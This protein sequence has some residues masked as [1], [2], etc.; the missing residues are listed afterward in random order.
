MKQPLSQL[1]QKLGLYLAL[2]LALAQALA[3][4]VWMIFG[5]LKKGPEFYQKPWGIPAEVVLDNYSAALG[6]SGIGS[7]LWNSVTVVLLGISLL[8]VTAGTTAYGLARFEFRGK[9]AVLGLILMTMIIPPEVLTVP[10]FFTLKTL[11]LLGT[12]PGLACLYASGSFG[13]SVFLLRG[14]FE[15]IPIAIEEAALIDGA[16]FV[17]MLTR[18]VVPLAWP[19]FI[20]VL[21]IQAMGMWNDLYLALVFVAD[22]QLATAP[23]GLLSFF[24]RDSIDWPLLLAALCSL[25]LPVLLVFAMLQRRIVGGLMAGGVK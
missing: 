18:V 22:P 11:G 5:S 12:L 6:T 4:I 24:Q 2:G 16:G 20:N 10:L 14:Y 23:V 3:P 7:G 21:A 9:S 17:S 1:W 25:T 15:A 13:M 8:T 19:G